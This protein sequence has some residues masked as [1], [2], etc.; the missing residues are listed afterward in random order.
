MPP[1]TEHPAGP[2]EVARALAPLIAQHADAAEAGRHLPDFLV[3]AFV[4]ARLFQMYVP[5]SLGGD[6]VDYVESIGAIEVLARAD[7]SAAWNV[8]I[9]AG[10]GRYG[11]FMDPRAA[12]EMFA[13]PRAVSA[14]AFPIGGRLIPERGGYRLSGRWTYCSG[15]HQSSW[16]LA[17]CLVA[18]GDHARREADGSPMM[19]IAILPRPDWEIVESW[20]TTGMRGTGSHDI[21]I[22]DA[23]I[24]D[25]R[26]FS[27]RA[28][29]RI[30][31]PLYRLPAF[32]VLG[33][34]PAATCLGIARHAIDR[35][36][37]LATAKRHTVS[38]ALVG[39]RPVVQLRL[40]E[41]EVTL[42]AGR[43]LYFETL[44]SFWAA[45][46]ADETPTLE[47][48]AS[49]RLACVHA[50][51]SAVR[52][53]DLVAGVSGSSA[54]QVAEPIERLWRD[55]HTAATH[56]TVT[57]VNYEATGRVLLGLEPGA[58]LL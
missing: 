55:V 26:T 5:K 33:P 30:D 11:A 37:E 4:D 22:E 32:S 41:A 39:D 13:D 52:A 7:G 44:A 12:A 16:F 58:A 3:D 53:V 20:N 35:F 25:H 42:R 6:E 10:N 40:S 14:A 56:A 1:A 49:L 31:A 18:G 46:C 47:D 54:I 43:A 24:P 27:L 29:R 57:E 9:G 19:L 38:N 28:P 34:G 8:M 36:V 17:G 2:F 51:Q 45:V 15:C 21:V 50:A 23:F 48:R